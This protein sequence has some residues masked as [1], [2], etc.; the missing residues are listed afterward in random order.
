MNGTV[1]IAKPGR[2]EKREILPLFTPG[3]KWSTDPGLPCNRG[4]ECRLACH[5]HPMILS[6]FRPHW[7]FKLCTL[8]AIAAGILTEEEVLAGAKGEENEN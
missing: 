1:H 3:L 5:A 8:T 2:W 4:R 6:S 7:Y